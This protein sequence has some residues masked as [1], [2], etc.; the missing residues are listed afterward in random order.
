MNRK[1]LIKFLNS[2]KT[3][4]KVLEIIN[5]KLHSD[6]A[7]V[8]DY[9]M[10]YFMAGGAVANT[11]YY[12]LNKEK[13][14]E[15]IINDVDLFFFDN[16]L[17]YDWSY[18]T[19]DPNLFI[20]A[21]LDNVAGVDGYGRTWVGPSGETMRMFSSERFGI[22]NKVSIS[23]STIK[24]SIQGFNETEYYKTLL[25][26]FDLNCCMA[27]L[28]RVNGN[29]VYT[30]DFLDFLESNMIEVTNVSQ[31]L[32]TS[33]RLKNKSVQLGVDTS[34]FDCEM[35][36]IKHSFTIKKIHSIGPE[37]MEKVKNNREFV[38][39]HFDFN[40]EINSNQEVFNYTVN[41][42]ELEKYYNNF[43]IHHNTKLISFWNLFVRKKNEE[44]FNKVLTFYNKIYSSV[45]GGKNI[46]NQKS[47]TYEHNLSNIYKETVFGG[48][49]FVSILNMSP[50]Y[51][52]CDFIVEDLE[53]IHSFN[54]YMAQE[55]FSDGSIFVTKNVK[56][57]LKMIEY[58]TK[59]FVDKYGV[60]KRDLLVKLISR[61]RKN[62][63]HNLAVLDYE[64]K[65]SIFNKLISGIWIKSYNKFGTTDSLR[66]KFL[67]IKKL[68]LIEFEW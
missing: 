57:Q 56:E 4:N 45:T 9:P 3:Y 38:L 64:K 37:W 17:S 59:K 8:D 22:I 27:G 16:V 58:I 30:E 39:E 2:G 18:N 53:Q 41:S 34:N 15:P 24:K 66:H 60:F 13:F 47:I 55:T 49:D 29:I 10:H 26:V 32:Q 40:V 44:A 19:N 33:V 54:N 20:H 12:L 36:L 14:E 28:D 68:N 48:F 23:V 6:G 5:H 46:Q 67:P 11:I 21:T 61:S 31:P 51:F 35:N 62:I 42:F 25:T 7:G 52:D 1:E 43:Y 63:E 50:S 65:V